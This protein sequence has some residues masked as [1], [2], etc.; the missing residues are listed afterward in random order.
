MFSCKTYIHIVLKGV[1][2]FEERV[3][4][5]QAS[6]F[7]EAIKMAEDEGQIYADSIG[8]RFLNFV[9]CYEAK[10]WSYQKKVSEI[11]SLIRESKLGDDE[12][13]DKFEDTGR[14]RCAEV[15]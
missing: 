3:V 11:Y 12:Y 7:E 1:P 15:E 4:S 9:Q 8:G 5:V 10:E 6:T 13:I 2:C 14:E